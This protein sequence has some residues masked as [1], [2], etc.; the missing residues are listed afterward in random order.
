MAYSSSERSLVLSY[1]EEYSARDI[2]PFVK[3]LRAT[4]YAGDIVLFTVNVDADCE[5]L[6]AKHR[7]QQIPVRRV[8]MKQ[9]IRIPEWLANSLGIASPV[10]PDGAINIRLA[11]LFGALNMETS[12]LARR[13]AQLLWH[14]NSGRFFYYQQFLEGHPEYEQVLIADVRDVMF[15]CSPFEG[16]M[17]DA[18]YLFEEYPATPLGEQIDN[19]TWIKRLYGRVALATL[20]DFPIVCAGV[21]MGT[22]AQ[23]LECVEGIADASVTNYVG[24]GTDQG[25]LNHLVRTGQLASAAVKPYGSGPAMHLGIA[26]RDT[27][28]TDAQGRVLN[29]E[30]EVCNILHQYDRHPELA[31]TLLEQNNR[32]AVAAPVPG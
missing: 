12:A 22:R 9:S 27:I 32:G 21:M 15:Q 20:A 7:V 5:S 2:A 24:W 10:R 18:L 25:T 1:I 28:R 23:V 17:E 11:T 26:P 30:G 6:F 8:D 29:R 14:C 31:K 4:G 13:I 3:S 16:G 19:A